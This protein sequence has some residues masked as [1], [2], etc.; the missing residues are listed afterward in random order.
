MRS[1]YR[2]PG[3]E[4]PEELTTFREQLGRVRDFLESTQGDKLP[5]ERLADYLQRLRVHTRPF[6]EIDSIVCDALRRLGVSCG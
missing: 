6:P 3:E 5:G 1:P 4:P 2:D